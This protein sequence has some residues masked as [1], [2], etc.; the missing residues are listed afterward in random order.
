[1]N[2]LA[3]TF[4]IL[5]G[6]ALGAGLMYVLDPDRGA[7]RRARIRRQAQLGQKWTAKQTQLAQKWTAKQANVAVRQAADVSKELIDQARKNPFVASL[8]PARRSLLSKWMPESRTGQIAVV[9]LGTAL[10]ATGGRY[11][12]RTVGEPAVH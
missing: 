4:G 2:R 7:L 9:L 3:Q 6:A 8:L 11:A 5:G 10:A 1:M 12:A